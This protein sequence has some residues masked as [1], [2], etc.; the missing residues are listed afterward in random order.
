MVLPL[1][2]RMAAPGVN[3]MLRRYI[4]RFDECW[5][6]DVE[7][8]NN[9]SGKL[10][11]GVKLKIPLRFIGPLSRLNKISGVEKVY[12]LL[13]LLSGPEPQRSLLEEKVM[14][15]AANT[16]LKIAVVQ[17]LVGKGKTKI[18]RDNLEI[19]TFADASDVEELMAKSKT[20]M[21]RSGY[22][23]AMDVCRLGGKALLVPTPGQP[24]QEYLA[25]YMSQYNWCLSTPQHKLDIFES[26]E[27]LQRVGGFPQTLDFDAHNQ[28]VAD[29]L[30]TI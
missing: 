8:E 4:N 6:P 22:S 12:D 5:V 24:E 26:L 19:R 16:R 13:A 20:V 25:K 15:Q 17:G 9:L 28:A 23:S 21:C 1:F 7:G 2:V 30:Q 14:Q 18:I 3:T 10:S 11:H 29:W 27:P